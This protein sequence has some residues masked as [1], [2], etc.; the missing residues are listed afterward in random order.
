M[1][2]ISILF[3][4]LIKKGIEMSELDKDF[5]RHPVIIRPRLKKSLYLFQWAR[6][7]DNYRKVCENF[8]FI[9]ENVLGFEE[10]AFLPLDMFS[11]VFFMKIFLK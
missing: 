8:Y 4:D 6:L 2:L 7:F 9:F 11:R 5:S 1:F 10:N 3:G